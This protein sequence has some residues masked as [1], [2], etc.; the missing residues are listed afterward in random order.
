MPPRL[1]QGSLSGGACHGCGKI[2][3][4][5]RT[6]KALAGKTRVWGAP[7]PDQP[8]FV[9][10]GCPCRSLE[11]SPHSSPCPSH[12]A[13]SS[14]HH[15]LSKI[16]FPGYSSCP[17]PPSADELPKNQGW[18]LVGGC[19]AGSVSVSKG[20]K[21][22]CGDRLRAGKSTLK[23]RLCDWALK[24]HTSTAGAAGGC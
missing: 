13:A 4:P 15:R 14:H 12:A 1:A 19:C 16:A 11:H 17:R 24:T 6:P 5:A 9:L 20:A 7:L 2:T 3:N 21:V 8:G 23:Y 10:S 18:G 22:Q